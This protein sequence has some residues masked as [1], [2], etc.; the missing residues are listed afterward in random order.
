MFPLGGVKNDSTL[1]KDS[2]LSLNNSPTFRKLMKRHSILL[3]Q[4]AASSGRSKIEHS[5]FFRC[6]WDKCTVEEKELLTSPS[7]YLYPCAFGLWCISFFSTLL[8]MSVPFCYILCRVDGSSSL[9][10]RSL[11]SLLL[12]SPL[13]FVPPSA[14]PRRLR[15]RLRAKCSPNELP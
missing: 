14:S 6:V 2:R 1:R 8:M 4:F 10:F 7:L 11:G 9:F 3:S 13:R 12:L 5:Q 15:L